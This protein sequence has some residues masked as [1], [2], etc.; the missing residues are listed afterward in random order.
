M[1]LFI[2]WSGDKSEVVAL[3]L[4]EFL[5]L[6]IPELD[7]F[8]SPQ[9]SAGTNWIN[10]MGRNL[11]E[12]DYGILCIT[13][14]NLYTQWINFEAGALWKGTENTPVCPLLIDLTAAELRG[15]IEMFQSKRLDED[16]VKQ[17]C[18]LL[19]RKTQLDL[20]R[21]ERNFS[22]IWTNIINSITED[23]NRIKKREVEKYEI[24]ILKPEEHSRV[25]K[26]FM[27]FISCKIKPPDGDAWVLEYDP[28]NYQYWPKK[29]IR[30]GNKTNEWSTEI[31]IGGKEGRQREI[32][33]VIVG[34]EG[35]VLFDYSRKVVEE[36]H[37]ETNIW[38][39]IKYL[40]SDIIT[41]DS[42]TI[43]INEAN[44]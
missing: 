41:C 40:T 16:G 35:K 42:V 14:E 28:D 26:T 19:A 36:I 25:A 22:L 15:P 18:M 7:I 6:I 9:I 43:I 27:I 12:A 13:K 33:I 30:F 23:F 17:L 31:S 39:G 21:A 4:S 32:K 37:K 10:E 20:L 38:P 11:I 2:G 1:K 29:A 44:S 24:K 34:N 5:P 8:F 3:R